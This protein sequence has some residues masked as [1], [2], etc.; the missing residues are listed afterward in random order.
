MISIAWVDNLRELLTRGGVV[1]DD[2]HRWCAHGDKVRFQRG[3]NVDDTPEEWE[4]GELYYDDA[5]K[6][7]YILEDE[8]GGGAWYRLGSAWEEVSAWEYEEARNV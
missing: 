3:R 6:M 4:H 7:W 1:E 5:D 8:S 2:S